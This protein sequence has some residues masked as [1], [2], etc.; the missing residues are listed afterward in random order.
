M[1]CYLYIAVIFATPPPIARWVSDLSP[2]GVTAIAQLNHNLAASPATAAQFTSRYMCVRARAYT[3]EIDFERKLKDSTLCVAL[4]AKCS[5]ERA[6]PHNR[7][8]L[9]Y[10]KS[11]DYLEIPSTRLLHL[12]CIRNSRGRNPLL[13]RVNTIDMVYTPSKKSRFRVKA[14]DEDTRYTWKRAR[15]SFGNYRI[16]IEYH[17]DNYQ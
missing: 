13:P 10:V 6:C 9:T 8:P 4:E 5:N 17:E 16:I 3:A 15:G 12:L 7:M 1:K 2:G 14:F 11:V